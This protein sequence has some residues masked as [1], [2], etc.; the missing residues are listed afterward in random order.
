[1]EAAGAYRFSI[2]LLF[3]F[4]AVV[5]IVLMFLTAPYGR[6]A[7]PGWGFSLPEKRGRQIMESPAVIV[8]AACLF[9]G[10]DRGLTPSFV[11]A[12]L[13]LF[14]E[15]HYIYRTIIFP[16]RMR[17]GKKQFPALLVLFAII[18]NTF[19]G[20]VNGYHLFLGHARYDLAWLLDPRFIFGTIVFVAGFAT[21]VN[22]DRLLRA[23]RA[24]GE[25]GYSIPHGGMFRYVSSPNYLG[26]IIQWIGW[27]ILTWSI[28]G[29]AFAAFSFANL[30]PRALANHRW[31]RRQFPGEYPEERKA[32]IPFL[33]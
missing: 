24:P 1:M 26:E 8:I 17:E 30:F 21:H 13:L 25:T 6:H 4:A 7:R 9:V 14:W 31:Y 5:F 2:F 33:L 23:L 3:V 11:S 15:V 16:S 29:L 19:N 28:A 12:L 10:W 22:S 18:F 20:F 32:I 27:A